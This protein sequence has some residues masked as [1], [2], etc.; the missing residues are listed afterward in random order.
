MPETALC[1]KS[2]GLLGSA[3]GRVPGLIPM[4]DLA[5]DPGG[6]LGTEPDHDEIPHQLNPAVRLQGDQSPCLMIDC[7]TRLPA[8]NHPC[9][10]IAVAQAR[11]RDA[12]AGLPIL[13]DVRLIVEPTNL[14]YNQVPIELVVDDGV[15]FA[16]GPSS[17]YGSG[18]KGLP[19]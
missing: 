9:L 1:T 15:A 13:T 18:A 16:D 6:G 10:I 12:D 11:D 2:L 8:P 4:G 19:P 3:R 5:G 7:R 14:D 17:Y